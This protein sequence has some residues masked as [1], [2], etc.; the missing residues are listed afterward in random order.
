M[1]TFGLLGQLKAA[2]V[3]GEDLRTKYDIKVVN[4]WRN[5]SEQPLETMPLAMCDNRTAGQ[6][7]NSSM[8][9]PTSKA[10]FWGQSPR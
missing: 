8:S 6:A 9:L 2:G 3:T 5:C 1:A 10:V 7:V 4:A